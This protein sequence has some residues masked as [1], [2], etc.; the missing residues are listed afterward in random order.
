M[1]KKVD[2]LD[3]DLDLD[4]VQAELDRLMQDIEPEIQEYERQMAAMPVDNRPAKVRHLE[5]ARLLRE[6]AS[7]YFHSKGKRCPSC[8]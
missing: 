2:D 1:R 5:A 4:N 6:A 7:K 8:A 3:L